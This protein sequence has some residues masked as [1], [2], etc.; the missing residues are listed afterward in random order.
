LDNFR[1]Q[2][3]SGISWSIKAQIFQQFFSISTSIILARLLNPVDFGLVAMIT[4]ITGFAGIFVDMG[5]GS[6]LIQKKDITQSELSSV[7]WFNLVAGFLLTLIFITSAQFIATFYDEPLLVPLTIFIS[8]NFII[9]AFGVIQKALLTKKVD[10]KTLFKVQFITQPI[11]VVVG[12][13]MAWKGFGPWSIA[14]QIVLNSL[15]STS[16]LWLV[17]NWKPSWEFKWGSIKGLLGFSL[18]LFGNR[19]LNYWVR[20]LDNL[21]I[22]K[23]IGTDSLGVYSKA[24]KFF[25]VSAD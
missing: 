2:T 20:N 14:T 4:V 16:M 21:L 11:A 24:Y 7:F 15:L 10:F 22:G 3:I 12:I 9:S 19:S 17:S 25:N 6:A 8:F 1:D 18:S 23:F 13:S 5:L